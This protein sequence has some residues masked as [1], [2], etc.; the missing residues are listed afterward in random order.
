M[1]LG[2]NQYNLAS[3]KFKKKSSIFYHFYWFPTYPTWFFYG[4]NN[5]RVGSGSVSRDYGSCGS[6]S[7]RN[8]YGS[9]ALTWCWTKV[10]YS[11]YVIQ[12][13]NSALRYPHPISKKVYQVGTGSPFR[14]FSNHNSSDFDFV[15]FWYHA[16][17]NDIGLRICIFKRIRI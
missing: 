8:I 5:V 11:R 12:G 17:W 10:M 14:T 15:D 6:G 3:K 4:R 13:K 1:I 16:I 2:I 9:T 7:E